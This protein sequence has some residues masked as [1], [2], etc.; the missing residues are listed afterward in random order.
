M[1]MGLVMVVYGTERGLGAMTMGTAI[2]TLDIPLQKRVAFVEEVCI[3]VKVEVSIKRASY[4][5]FYLVHIIFF[6]KLRF[7]RMFSF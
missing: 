3:R 2:R 1:Q 6:E 7:R 4:C 5:K